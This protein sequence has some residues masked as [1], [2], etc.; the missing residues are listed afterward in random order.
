M[1][2]VAFWRGCCAVLLAALTSFGVGLLA[3]APAFQAT[4]ADA[5]ATNLR[6][7]LPVPA[8]NV[9]ASTVFVQGTLVTDIVVFN[10]DSGDNRNFCTIGDGNTGNKQFVTLGAAADSHGSIHLRTPVAI[11]S[12]V[13][14]DCIFNAVIYVFGHG[15]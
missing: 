7:A 14:A 1:L 4:Q 15:P 13:K 2:G 6:E 11:S 3:R 12:G 8:N 9:A 10:T 5:A